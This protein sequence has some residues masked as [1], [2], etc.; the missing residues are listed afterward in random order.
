MRKYNKISHLIPEVI[1]RRAEG[2]T[3]EEI[4]KTM[5]LS[6]QRICQIK[7]AAER[8]EK[9]TKVWGFPFSVR[10]FKLL[11]RL[12]VKSRDEALQLY[13]SGHIYPNAVTGF[14]WKSYHEICEWLGVP[15]LRHRPGQGD[16]C[17]HCQ[18]PI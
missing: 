15:M 11:Q 12:S 8:Q 2:E 13:L 5:N 17:P 7:Q 1:R 6:R 9:I 4:G 3:Y 14:G 18:K 16:I 10:S